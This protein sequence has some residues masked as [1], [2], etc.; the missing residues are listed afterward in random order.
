TNELYAADP[1][2]ILFLGDSLTEGYGLD[3]QKAFPYLI[4]DQLKKSE[5]SKKYTF[6]IIQGGWSGATS[7][8]AKSKLSWF[9]KGKPKLMVLGIGANDGL[10]GIKTELTQKNIEEII[11]KSQEKNIKVVL[12]QMKLPRNYGKKYYS[13]FE[14]MY[15]KIADKFKITLVPFILEEIAGKKE[16]N[17]ADGIH[18]NEKG[19]EHIAKKLYPF[20]QEQI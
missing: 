15:K 16:M 5:K 9:Y 12:L 4:L 13:D 19:H 14:K 18:P 10:R 8:A 17:L 1:Y 11:T 6:S 3:T 2:K 7:T 20:I